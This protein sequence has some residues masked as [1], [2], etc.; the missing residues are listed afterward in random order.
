MTRLVRQSPNPA[1]ATNKT[2][3][4]WRVFLILRGATTPELQSALLDILDQADGAQFVWLKNLAFAVAN[5]IS[6]GSPERAVALLKRTTSSEGF[7]ILDLGDD[8]TLEHKAIW[9]AEASDPMEE[10]WCQRLFSSENNAVLAREVLAAERFG[11]ADFIKSM[12]LDLAASEDSLDQAYAISIAGYSIRS[13]EF[14]VTLT[15]CINNRGVSG[16]AAQ[17]AFSEHEDAICA[18][19]WVESMWNATTPEEFWRC[20][21]IAKTSMDARVSPDAPT[22][23][24]WA[25][26]SPVF[27][28]ARKEA[29]KDRNKE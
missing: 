1:P 8:L 23:S 20:M 7:V 4:K 28:R 10:F 14:A 16:R 13:E 19:H 9:G 21:I 6:G 12:V 3:Q 18:R 29:I 22:S 2:R 11:A 27:R 15:S 5:L 24:S 25:H 17:H 26:Y